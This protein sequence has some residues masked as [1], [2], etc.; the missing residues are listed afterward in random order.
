MFICFYKT[1]S[2]IH[3]QTLHSGGSYITLRH[4][5]TSSFSVRMPFYQENRNFAYFHGYLKK[6]NLCTYTLLAE[7]YSSEFNSACVLIIPSISHTRHV[8][9]A[10]ERRV[11]NVPCPR[12][13]EADSRVHRRRFRV[14][15]RL[16]LPYVALG[17]RSNPAWI[18][19]H[20][21]YI[22]L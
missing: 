21:F 16:A 3:Q 14:C 9:T 1:T 17:T 10:G 11:S 22:L 6:L 20:I 8:E 18:F 19:V 7:F 15:K 12:V 2:A 5:Q 13:M 4:I